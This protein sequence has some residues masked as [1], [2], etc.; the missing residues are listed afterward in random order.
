[1][2]S[3]VLSLTISL[4][5]AT[6]PPALV[7]AQWAYI[8]SG[9]GAAVDSKGVPYLGEKFPG[10][11]TP[12]MVD[13]IKS[14]APDYPYQEQARRHQGVGYFKLILDLKTGSVTKVAILKSTGFATLDACAVAAFRQWRWKPG[15]W[16]VI[17]EPVRFSLSDPRLAPGSVPLR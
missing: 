11:L 17:E 8:D 9:T 3:R 14:I 16:K 13:R 4:V 12:W 6:V 7:Q 1:M 2:K 10:R 15:K 5:I